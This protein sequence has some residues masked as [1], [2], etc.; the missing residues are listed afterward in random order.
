MP[1]P[2]AV[3]SIGPRFGQTA[4]SLHRDG[5]P[6]ITTLP[7]VPPFFSGHVVGLSCD[8]TRTEYEILVN[9]RFTTSGPSRSWVMAASAATPNPDDA[10]EM[11][12]AVAPPRSELIMP[13]T[14]ER[15]TH[16]YRRARTFGISV[17]RTVCDREIPGLR[18]LIL[19]SRQARALGVPYTSTVVAPR[20]HTH[21][22]SRGRT[23]AERSA[24][25]SF[26]CC[27][28]ANRNPCAASQ[29]RRRR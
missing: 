28:R 1:R 21:E 22:P 14:P 8:P 7:F 19:A 29:P 15:A 5:G 16:D 3:R 9:E 4:T 13:G 12:D 20:C 18:Q 10:P 27:G 2:P 11:G 25:T 6:M 23:L 26:A 24:G 17:A